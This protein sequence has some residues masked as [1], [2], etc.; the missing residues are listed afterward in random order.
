MRSVGIRDLKARLS[1][2]LE[3]V[4][5]GEILLVTDRG[6]V[7]AELRPAGSGAEPARDELERRL[8]GW[9]RDGRVR[10]GPPNEPGWY[11]PSPLRVPAGTAD[12]VLEELRA[13]TADPVGPES[14]ARP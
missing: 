10:V 12:R 9:V 2:H 4:R 1:R 11:G 14:G 13:D 6:K 7:V 5:R 3:D 8:Q